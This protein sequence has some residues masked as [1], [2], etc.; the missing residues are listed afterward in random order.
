MLCAARA[1]NRP[2][3]LGLCAQGMRSLKRLFHERRME[4]DI[5]SDTLAESFIN[6]MPAW[7][8]ML[9]LSSSGPIK[10]PVGPTLMHL[11]MHPYACSLMH[12][13]VHPYASPCASLCILVHITLCTSI[14]ATHV[15]TCT[16]SLM[17]VGACATAAESVEIGAETILSGKARVVIVGGYDDFGAECQP[18]APQTK[19]RLLWLYKQHLSSMRQQHLKRKT[20]FSGFKKNSA[21][22]QRQASSGS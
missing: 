21:F 11:L 5:P 14:C 4:K 16:S 6:T 19:G 3:H 2:Y 22:L 18:A 7:I 13:L 20:G 10:T 1:P 12:L 9:L 8:N 15:P 17:Q